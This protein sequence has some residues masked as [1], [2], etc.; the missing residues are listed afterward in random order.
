VGVLRQG[1]ALRGSHKIS[2]HSGS[3]LLESLAFKTPNP[4]GMVF[5][6]FSFFFSIYNFTNPSLF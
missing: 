2:T 1:Q 6:F 4:D 3:I 5:F